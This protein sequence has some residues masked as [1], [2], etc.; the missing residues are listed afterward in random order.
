MIRLG[1]IKMIHFKDIDREKFRK[2]YDKIENN[3]PKGYS[4]GYIGNIWEKWQ[5]DDRGFYIEDTEGKKLGYG[6]YDINEIDGLWTAL[7]KKL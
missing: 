2:Y 5:S 7:E 6:Y 4:F 3:L 1:S